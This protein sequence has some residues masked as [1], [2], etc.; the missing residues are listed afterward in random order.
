MRNKVIPHVERI[1]SSRND[2][3]ISY[4]TNLA[5]GSLAPHFA[6]W[7]FFLKRK[8]TIR[9]LNRKADEPAFLESSSQ[10]PAASPSSHRATG[11]RPSSAH[12]LS[13]SPATKSPSPP[14][15]HLHFL[16]RAAAG[17]GRNTRRQTRPH[18]WHGAIARL[19]RP[20]AAR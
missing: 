20:R 3:S 10:A 8:I 15:P 9:R 6:T 18:R 7:L 13:P 19:T 2:P 4:E 1:F 5:P 16:P 11:H 17:Q 14:L 12:L